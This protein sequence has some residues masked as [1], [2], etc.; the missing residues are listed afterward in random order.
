MTKFSL[1]LGTALS[2]LIIGMAPNAWAQTVVSDN[3]KTPVKIGTI[4][5]SA[6]RAAQSR[7]P[8]KAPY[9]VSI[10]GKQQI[11]LASPATNAQTLLNQLPSVVAVSAGPN[12]MRTNIQFRA[13]NDG[14][15]SETFGGVALNDIFNAG[16]VNSASARNNQLVTLDDFQQV[17]AFRGVNNPAV[18]SY[19]SLGG[20]INYVPREAP[21]IA[22]GQAGVSYGSSNSFDTHVRID[23]GDIDGL[24]QLLS[25]RRDVD[26]SWLQ[27]AKDQNNHLYYTFNA[28]IF[29]GTGKVYGYFLYN[30]NRGLT[31]HTVPQ[32]LIAQYGPSYQFPTSDT[33][34]ENIDTNYLAVLGASQQFTSIFSGD[35]KFFFGAD[36]YTR[37]SFSN[38][39]M[40]QGATM[41]YQLPNAPATFP[42]SPNPGQTSYD[43]IAQF[44]SYPVG[45]QYHFYGYYGTEIGVQ[46][47]FTLDLPHNTIVFG[48]NLTAGHLHSREYWY[49]TAP[50]PQIP[51]YN[52]AW[53]EHDLRTLASVYLQDKISLLNDRLTITPGVKYLYAITKDHDGLG[54][55]YPIAGSVS[56][57]AHYLSPTVG[58]SFAITPRLTAYAA[59]GQNIKFPNISAYYGNVALQNAAGNY[60]V[61]PLHVSPEYVKDYEVGL[62]YT[63]H[64][65]T[66]A[67]DYYREDF[68]NTFI[69]S[70]SPITGTSTTSNGGHSRYD[71]EELQ[72][73]GQFGRLGSVPGQWSG[74]FNYAHNNAVFLSGF[75]SV[76]AGTVTAG[77]PLANVPNN[78]LSA[79]VSWAHQGWL[80][81]VNARYVGS[82]YLQQGFAGTPTSLQSPPYFLLNA[83]LQKTVKVHLGKVS[84]LR[85]SLNLDNILNRRYY[86]ADN[87]YQDNNG[88]NYQSVLLGAPRAVYFSVT[89]LF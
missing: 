31:P 4:S 51:G 81:D 34:S 15:F 24:R 66:A 86:T 88:N 28:P 63:L 7:I 27:N 64:G 50:V 43:P 84:A 19:N 52:N 69:T 73:V 44:G 9:T 67:V 62:R 33:Y 76:Y 46:P 23:T 3:A 61:T 87:I 71:G 75:S 22:G 26:G 45:A 16:V 38:P 65:V 59:Y 14:Q 21:A 56:N 8:K 36:N 82:E 48:G 25:I 83:T 78:L 72:L 53:N 58:A 57:T 18:N 47:K 77:Q 37:T 17:E 85:L 32:A 13:F 35:L 42:Y 30:K 1:L 68:S 10:I 6:S 55:F 11:K 12:G 70:T 5:K 54:F 2:G 39:Y 40:L 20:T 41:P 89:A 79:G 74:Y 29:G 49:G 60:V 80:A